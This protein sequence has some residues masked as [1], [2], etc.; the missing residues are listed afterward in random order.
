MRKGKNRG[1][2]LTNSGWDDPGVEGRGLRRAFKLLLNDLKNASNPSE[3]AEIARAMAYVASAKSTLYKREWEEL[4]S[5]LDDLE[6][7][8]GIRK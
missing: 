2:K 3:R 7:S 8:M 4:R 1:K 6:K 5:R